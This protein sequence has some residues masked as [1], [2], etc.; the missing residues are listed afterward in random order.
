MR[1]TIRCKASKLHAD[2]SLK[3]ILA[4]ASL[5]KHCTIMEQLTISPASLTPALFSSLSIHVP[6]SFDQRALLRHHFTH[7]QPLTGGYGDINADLFT[8]LSVKDSWLG[9]AQQLS[10]HFLPSTGPHVTVWTAASWPL[11]LFRS[12]V[13]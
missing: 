11:F 6:N 8:I 13:K 12:K 10:D 2:S 3:D 5:R 1:Y 7:K 4:G 9:L